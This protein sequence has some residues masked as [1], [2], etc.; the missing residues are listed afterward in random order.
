MSLHALSHHCP[1]LHLVHGTSF[2][3]DSVQD[4]VNAVQ[5]IL[6]TTRH[7]V[8][9]EDSDHTYEDKYALVDTMTNVAIAASMSVLERLGLSPD[10]LEKVLKTVDLENK[11]LS[12]HFHM[13]QGCTFMKET[14]RKVTQSEI[15]IEMTGTGETLVS[16]TN[17]VKVK[18]TVQEFHWNFTAPYRLVLRIGDIEVQLAS[19]EDM[20][21]TMIVLGSPYHKSERRPP[22]PF[23][24]KAIHYEVSLT[25]LVQNIA[26]QDGK[27][28]SKF[29]VDRAQKSCKTPRRNEEVGAAWKFGLLLNKF[30]QDVENAFRGVE[31]GL[32]KIVHEQSESACI[33]DTLRSQQNAIFDPIIP[34][35]ENNTVLPQSDYNLFL[36][37]HAT[38]LD[39]FIAFDSK[40]SL[41]AS[42][43][44]SKKEGVVLTILMQLSQIFQ[45]WFESIQYVEDMLYNQMVK[46]IG[47]QLTAK[48]FDEFISFYSKGLFAEAYGPGV[49]SYAIRQTNHYPDGMLS[50]ESADTR[51]PIHTIVRRIK[52]EASPSLTIPVDAA[53]S[54]EIR[55]DCFV[56]GW[57]QHRWGGFSDHLYRQQLV[58]RAHQF[59]S[60]IVV[61]GVMGPTNTF[62]PKSAIILQN[63]DEVL[64]PLLSKVMPSAKEF[65]DSIKSLSPEQRAF[66]ETYRR[67]QLESSVFGVCVIQIK[68]QLEK[69]L[70]L[71]DGALT[72]EIELTRDLMSLF[73]DYHIP[74]DLLSYD[75]PTTAGILERVW[76]VQAYVK[77]VMDVMDATKAKQLE[78]ERQKAKVREEMAAESN[79]GSNARVR[80]MARPEALFSAKTVGGVARAM[81]ATA[82]QSAEGRVLEF[83]D[84][85]DVSDDFSSVHEPV[86]EASESREDSPSSTFTSDDSS[87]PSDFTMIPRMLDSLFKKHDNDGALKST[88]IKAQ[89][90]WQR[91]RQENLLVKSQKAVLSNEDIASETSQAIDLLRAISR[92]GSL[93]IESSELHVVI[94]VSHC[95]VNQIME[96]LIEGNINPIAKV[97][98]SMLMI[99]SVIHGVPEG[100]LLGV[101]PRESLDGGG[102]SSSSM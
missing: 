74:S 50:I 95:F 49:F 71:P 55:G 40:H 44:L 69:L 85:A 100:E 53:T 89:D 24:S 11:P 45:S 22:P 77:A 56:H 42:S 64:I 12:L 90:P 37:E 20:T 25:W 58:A 27:P 13:D 65:T 5:T 97:E 99:A 72:K 93:S 83:A 32:L 38:T 9:P 82:S 41:F 17:N 98:R 52:A 48:D 4:A 19:R 80:P 61:L 79:A 7:P 29:S 70:N 21:T 86:R 59:S 14:E 73:V 23:P 78:S 101:K 87:S 75:G 47:M 35:F 88:I 81:S 16:G 15:E 28:T 102:D 2:C 8:V 63:K 66:A 67:F 51:M 60:F 18:S 57:I 43:F 33:T 26:L 92:S 46:A 31:Y 68:P 39:T 1:S 10:I 34:L 6:D 96:T 76:K 94:A 91:W 3:S 84:M 54:V 30:A 36:T 62:I